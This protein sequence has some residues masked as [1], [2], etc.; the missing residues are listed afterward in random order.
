[1][2]YGQSSTLTKSLPGPPSLPPETRGSHLVLEF[3]QVHAQASKPVRRIL[4]MPDPALRDET[5]AH[6]DGS[7]RTANS[8]ARR[9]RWV[10]QTLVPGP[11]AGASADGV[12]AATALTLKEQMIEVEARP[13]QGSRKISRNARYSAELPA[14]SP[15]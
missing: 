1:M 7:A 12:Q 15:S 14:P 13:T 6:L 8:N 9:N 2:I 4:A 10:V 3:G 5:V 11:T